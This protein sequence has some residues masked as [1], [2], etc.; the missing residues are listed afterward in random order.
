[1][2]FRVAAVFAGALALFAP[3][4]DAAVK[5]EDLIRGAVYD[6]GSKDMTKLPFKQLVLQLDQNPKAKGAVMDKLAEFEASG[7]PALKR[8]AAEG[9]LALNQPEKAAAVARALIDSG[10]RDPWL[11]TVAMKG[12]KDAQEKAELAA[13][14]KKLI[15]EKKS[16]DP[17][18]MKDYGIIVANAK[19]AKG[20]YTGGVSAAPVAMKAASFAQP[21]SVNPRSN[22][23]R[24]NVG[25]MKQ[26]AKR[27]NECVADANCRSTIQSVLDKS[28]G[29]TPEDVQKNMTLLASN[30]PDTPTSEVRKENAGAPVIVIVIAP[31]AVNPEGNKKAQLA[32][33]SDVLKRAQILK[34]NEEVSPA[35]LE[36][37]GMV[38]GAMTYMNFDAAGESSDNSGLSQYYKSLAFTWAGDKDAYPLDFNSYSDGT[39]RWYATKAYSYSMQGQTGADQLWWF[40]ADK[41]KVSNDR[42]SVAAPPGLAQE[43]E[44]SQKASKAG[45]N[46]K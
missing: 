22:E 6:S 1:M 18:L 29:I 36:Y 43:L 21:S 19:L 31:Q 4:S 10:V 23:R 42:N 40:A 32:A 13:G 12:T 33:V 24:V 35:W 17:E 8:Q 39:A 41:Y 45:L 7:D 16:A 25:E 20:K 38:F 46:L 5:G 15:D 14:A 37:A 27:L 34:E 9:Y 2:V 28:Q 26:F 44:V 11:F 30:N 3:F